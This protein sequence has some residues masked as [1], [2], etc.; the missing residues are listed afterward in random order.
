MVNRGPDDLGCVVVGLEERSPSTALL[1]VA[2][3]EAERRG[4]ALAV[5]TV[6]QHHVPAPDSDTTSAPGHRR[7]ELGLVSQVESLR[8]ERPWLSVTIFPLPDDEVGSNREPLCSA[9]LLVIGE[10]GTTGVRAFSPETV[11]WRLL[12]AARCPVLVVPD[13]ARFGGLGEPDRQRPVVLAGLSGKRSDPIVISAAYAEA[14]RRHGDLQLLH[15]YPPAHREPFQHTL[16]RAIDVVHQATRQAAPPPEIRTSVILSQDAPVTAL[17]R[18]ALGAAVLVLAARSGS[19]AGLISDA[20][21]RRVFVEA[22]CPVL[23][24]PWLLID[25][26]RTRE[27]TA[28]AAPTSHPKSPRSMKSTTA[29]GRT[30]R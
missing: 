21:S 6:L 26:D 7:G 24:V 18:Q 10:H 16:L 17:C 19:M 11:S 3:D 30:A 9:A 12:R 23:I 5:V 2:A 22:P 15:A 28:E 4:A 8:A 1:S 25:Q 14:W 27:A 20:V 13:R 29:T